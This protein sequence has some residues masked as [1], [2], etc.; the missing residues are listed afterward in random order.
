M[1]DTMLELV[2]ICQQKEFLCIHDNV[3]DLIESALNSK[4]LSINSQRLE[5]KQQEV[6]NVVERLAER[7][8]RSIQSLQNFRVVHKNSISLNNTS[9]ISSIHAVASILSTKEPEHSLSMGYK[10]LS[11]TLETKSDEITKSNAENLLPIPI[12][13]DDFEDIEYVEASLS[14]PEIVSVE[15]ENV[16]QQEEKEVDLEDISQIQDIVLREKLL[17]INRLIANIKSLNDNS[18]PDRVLN[19]FESDNSLSDNFSPKFETFCDYTEETRSGNTTHADNSIPDYD[20]FCFE[21]EPDQERLIYVLKSNIPDDSNDPLLEEADLFLAS[22]NSIPPSIE[23]VA[24][25]SEEDV[26][27]ED[28]IF[29]P[30]F[31]ESPI[32]IFI[33]KR[34]LRTI[35]FR[36][37]VELTT[38]K[39]L[40]HEKIKELKPKIKQWVATN[41]RNE[42]TRK[43]DLMKDLRILDDKIEAGLAL[44]D[45]C[46]KHIKILQEDHNLANLEDM[47]TIQK[48]RVKWDIKGDKNS[49]FFHGLINI[50]RRTQVINGIMHVGVWITNPIQIKEA[51]FNF[52]KKK[53][54]AN[55][56]MISFLPTLIS[57]TLQHSDHDFLESTLTMDE[58]KTTGGLILSGVTITICGL[59]SLVPLTIYIRAI[60]SLRTPFA[61]KWVAVL[62]FVFGK[63]F[64]SVLR[65]YVHVSAVGPLRRLI[66]DRILSSLDSPTTRDKTL[67][68]KINIFMWRLKLDKL[69]HRLNLSL[70][71]I[72][73]PV[74]SC[75][76][77]SG[78]VESNQNIFFG[79]VIAKDIW[80]IVRRAM[81]HDSCGGKWWRVVGSSGNG[82]EVERSREDSCGGKWWRVVG[83][84]GN[85]GEVERSEEVGVT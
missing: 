9:Q 44:N 70:R 24:D 57:H 5:K 10:H 49:K 60:S 30:D 52:F 12:Y 81:V 32:E 66:D 2:K 58:V 7:G 53:F 80:R 36:D 71:G 47:Y 20:S 38:R 62:K 65:L 63:T 74:I 55:D 82:R 69:P 16:I 11:I 59:R 37:R 33:S 14:D 40:S 35:K 27:S 68:R 51:F 77:C 26:Q 84:S 45:D 75:P 56:S 48:A 61:S 31:V 64:G 3:D 34:S 23:N 19:S 79:C 43:K 67:P 21:I 72:D 28:T 54:K 83:S 4:L 22:D 46:D 85:G 6:K 1:E 73:I 15:E 29:D 39:L 17:S 78:M 18:T 13:D 25:D 8:N 41:K 76:S 42:D 50:K